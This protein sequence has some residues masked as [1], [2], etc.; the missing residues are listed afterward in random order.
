M[1]ESRPKRKS[2]SGV[3]KAVSLLQK[4]QRSKKQP[5]QVEE[6][7]SVA[8][9]VCNKTAAVTVKCSICE[10]PLHRLCSN[11]VISSLS[12]NEGAAQVEDLGD[13]SFCSR[14]CY[15]AYRP[16]T[17]VDDGSSQDRPTQRQLLW[18]AQAEDVQPPPQLPPAPP[19][20]S[21]D[22]IMAEMVSFCPKDED[23]MDKKVYKA[24]GPTILNGKVTQIKFIKLKKDVPPVKQYLVSL[25]MYLY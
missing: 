23:W 24:V 16:M 3:A 13:R 1:S 4:K 7:Q 20:V 21:D 17:Q 18:R 2:S 11:D 9:A 15:H 12:M 5:L 14:E 19:I 6:A 10:C 25:I 8:C 22:W